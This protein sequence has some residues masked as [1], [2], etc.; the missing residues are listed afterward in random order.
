M[1]LEE[2]TKEAFGYYSCD[3][4]PQ[5]HKPIIAVC[6]DCNKPRIFKKYSY[7]AL[8][9]SC[10]GKDR[11]QSEET[12]NKIRDG[13]KDKYKGVNA[14]GYKSGK[15][16]C[17]CKACS[18]VFE[19]FPYQL[20]I[21]EGIFCC[22]KCEHGG[23]FNHNYGKRGAETSGWKG[24]PELRKARAVKHRCGYGY[25]PIYL[26]PKDG[27]KW[28]DHHIDFARTVPVLRKVHRAFWHDAPYFGLEGLWG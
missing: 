5:S 6:D 19:V 12:R 7:H 14:S 13:R 28:D 11:K 1:I 9:N 26:K 21:G 4:I 2:A 23:I 10:A 18:K 24:G 20:K 25:H 27:N 16:K 17:I 3:L 8:C 15:R 22:Y